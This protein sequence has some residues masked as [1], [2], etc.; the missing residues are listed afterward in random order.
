MNNLEDILHELEYPRK[1]YSESIISKKE[2]H[3]IN[4]YS[5]ISND[6]NN[7][8][9]EERYNDN[10]IK[11][12][13]L[14]HIIDSNYISKEEK[15]FSNK[16]NS[17][18]IF[19]SYSNKIEDK[20][21]SLE[22]IIDPYL[23]KGYSIINISEYIQDYELKE[24]SI[25]PEKVG[26]I[27]LSETAIPQLPEEY[28]TLAQSLAKQHP[29]I[30]YVGQTTLR[31][32]SQHNVDIL[33]FEYM[34]NG[35]LRQMH[36]VVKDKDKKEEVL[37]EFLASLGISTHSVYDRN[38]RLLLQHVGEEELR[39]I[40]TRGSESELRTACGK[41]LDKIS[42]IHVLASLH[43]P[44]L[45]EQFGLDLEVADYHTQF[46]SRF[47]EPVSGNSLIISPQRTRLMQAYS[48]FTQS[49]IPSSFTH[50]D[51]HI[52]NCRISP[53]E[54]FVIDY[55]WAKIGRKLDDISRF[56][57]SV[58][59]YRPGIDA[60]DF[61]QE[62]LKQYVEFHNGH[63]AEHN[64]PLMLPNERL[65]TALEYSLINDELYKVGEYILFAQ[66]HP[67]VQ[68]DKLQKS[69]ECF[70]RALDKIDNAMAKSRDYHTLANLRNALIYYAAVSP[71]KY[72]R[73][74]AEKY[75][76]PKVQVSSPLV[77]AA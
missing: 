36:V 60:Q 43:L 8:I 9:L 18:K 44:E 69:G 14:E 67:A 56:V 10:I 29:G 41:A 33:T 15:I 66:A 53:E 55:E 40:V 20:Y 1:S 50:G 26:R 45:R 2:L 71:H 6:Y 3:N 27:T 17:G 62:A 13:S 4:R 63:S 65:K 37:P 57:N 58:V 25:A 61:T 19:E 32:K 34:E 70:E 23:K 72:L 7:K 48:A 74:V 21:N 31:D 16:Y 42:K 5:I 51:F 73:E 54:C 38:A 49:F 24:P 68:E 59:R 28:K 35:E 77:L 39:D 12:K 75:K 11:P 30:K 64:A 22:K 52:G 46:T 47:L 76:A